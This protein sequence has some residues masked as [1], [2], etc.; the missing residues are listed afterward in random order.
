LAIAAGPKQDLRRVVDRLY[1]AVLS[2]PAS[3]NEKNTGRAFLQSAENWDEGVGDM[4]WALVCSP[5]FQY[6]K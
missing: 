1:R 4:V 2:R 6:V 3:V 5:E